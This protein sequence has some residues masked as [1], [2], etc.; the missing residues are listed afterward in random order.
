MS[1]LSKTE[2]KVDRNFD[3]VVKDHVTK[4]LRRTLCISIRGSQVVLS[5][6][7]NSVELARENLENMTVADLLEAMKVMDNEEEMMYKTTEKVEFP[8]MK[9]KFKGR[10]WT[11]QKAR[12]QLS[13]YLNIIGFGKGWTKKFREAADEPDGWPDEH[14]FE[15]F[16]HPSYA[17]MNVVNDILESLLKH[18]WFDAHTHPFLIEEQ[19]KPLSKKT[20][21][22]VKRVTISMDN[23]DEDPN[24]NSIDEDANIDEAENVAGTSGTQERTKGKKRKLVPYEEF[25]ARNISDREKVAFAL[26][27]VP[28]S[29]VR[30]EWERNDA[31][32]NVENGAVDN[33]E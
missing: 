13:T 3:K 5:G 26:G 30:K 20:Q 21:K 18:H 9:V 28:H 10:L 23:E 16:E 19:E 4:H 7:E 22:K 12:D 6:E 14:S 31:I 17:N 1:N 24:D 8:P 25:R 32:D 29:K 2:I 27:L 11:V 33:D 15:A